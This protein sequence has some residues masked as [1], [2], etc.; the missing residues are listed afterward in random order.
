VQ[1][2]FWLENDHERLVAER[3]RLRARLENAESRIREIRR[4][5]QNYR[6][7]NIL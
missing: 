3:S 6:R 1:R 5:N 4:D 7:C 2:R